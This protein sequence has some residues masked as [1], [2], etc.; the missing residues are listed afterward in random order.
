MASA[1]SSPRT[2]TGA[3]TG[4]PAIE[5]GEVG[6]GSTSEGAT[7]VATVVVSAGIVLAG[8]VESAPPSVRAGAQATVASRRAAGSQRRGRIIGRILPRMAAPPVAIRSTGYKHV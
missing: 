8:S 7:G 2:S 6:A 1:A 5:A 4:G 3:G